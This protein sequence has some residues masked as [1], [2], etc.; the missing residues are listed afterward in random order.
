LE[1]S[2]TPPFRRKKKPDLLLSVRSVEK[3]YNKIKVLDGVSLHLGRGE[4]L[5]VSGRSGSGK[6]TLIRIIAGLTGF[7]SGGM[8]VDGHSIQPG[9]RYPRKLIGRIGVVFQDLNLFPHMTALQNVALALKVV[10]KMSSASST[11]FSEQFLNKFGLHSKH[12]S[13]PNQLSGGEKQRVAIARTMVMEPLLLLLDEPTSS[14][15]PESIHGVQALIRELAA[16]GMPMIVVTHNLAFAADIGHRF[17]VL[18]NGRL[19]LSGTPAILDKLKGT[20]AVG[21]R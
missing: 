21:Y 1:Q 16:G 12:A 19:E 8:I 4:V 13:Y 15:D 7:S 17:A 9:R 20:T 18:E 10:K 6:T 14:L 2:G 3:S 11:A 5:T